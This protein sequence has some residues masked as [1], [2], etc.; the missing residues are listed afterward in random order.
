M[1]NTCTYVYQVLE[2]AYGG[3]HCIQWIIKIIMA[4]SI[5]YI[6]LPVKIMNKTDFKQ[7]FKM[8]SHTNP[9]RDWARLSYSCTLYTH[10][11]MTAEIKFIFFLHNLTRSLRIALIV[12]PPLPGPS[13]MH[14]LL[15]LL[16][17]SS[18]P[19]S[20]AASSYPNTQRC[21][22]MHFTSIAAW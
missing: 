17:P 14:P 16:S 19:S 6:Y 5:C 4:R 22:K 10:T 7:R 12:P 13:G 1:L 20:P 2:P 11:H 3:M 8:Y 21:S 15:F 9:V 18:S